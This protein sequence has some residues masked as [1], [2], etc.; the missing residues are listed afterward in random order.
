[1]LALKRKK[2]VKLNKKRIKYFLKNWKT[3]VHL[4]FLTKRF[5]VNNK[6]WFPYDSGFGCSIKRRIWEILTIRPIINNYRRMKHRAGA[7]HFLSNED[8]ELAFGEPKKF[9]YNH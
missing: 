9:P 8:F 7:L 6:W 2:I 4:I 5:G 1:M 3:G